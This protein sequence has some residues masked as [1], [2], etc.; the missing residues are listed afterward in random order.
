MGFEI[1]IKLLL[2][3]NLG[4]IFNKELA[5]KPSLPDQVSEWKQPF[6]MRSDRII[7]IIAILSHCLLKAKVKY[8]LKSKIKQ[9]LDGNTQVNIRDMGFPVNWFEH[10][11]LI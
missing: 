5:I 3:K 8:N 10:K 11:V 7:V 6:V 1:L 2:L 9:L 4:R